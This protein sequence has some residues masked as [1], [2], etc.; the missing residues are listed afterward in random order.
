M[1]ETFPEDILGETPKE[2]LP[3]G[4]LCGRCYDEVESD[5]DLQEAPCNE[6]PERFLGQPIGMYHCPDCGAMVLAG[7]E[8]PKV[9]KKCIDHLQGEG[10]DYPS[11]VCFDCGELYGSV[12]RDLSRGAF[13]MWE[14]KCAVC[15]NEGTVTHPRAF[16]HLNNEWRKH[17]PCDSKTSER[18][19]QQSEGCS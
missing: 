6:K 13:T 10:K 8:H 14:G 19:G 2:D 7:M 11:Q 9:C 4:P 15:E 16:G 12:K 17:K 5:E 1:S 18:T 3:M